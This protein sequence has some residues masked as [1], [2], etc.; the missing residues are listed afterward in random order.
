MRTETLRMRTQALRVAADALVR[1]PPERGER[2]GLHDRHHEEDTEGPPHTGR[3][4]RHA[5]AHLAVHQ[6]HIVTKHSEVLTD[7]IPENFHIRHIVAVF[8][9][10]QLV[11]YIISLETVGV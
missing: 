4:L 10:R 3:E 6:V 7:G 1:V 8:T 11:L 2:D 9:V 5:L